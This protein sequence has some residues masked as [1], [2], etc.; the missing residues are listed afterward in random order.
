MKQLD[1]TTNT[2]KRYL[3]ENSGATAIEYG[4]IAALIGVAMIAGLN[5]V[6]NSQTGSW[7]TLS[8]KVQNEL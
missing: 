8:D 4:L 2:L 1:W 6:G 7:G 3:R 5:A